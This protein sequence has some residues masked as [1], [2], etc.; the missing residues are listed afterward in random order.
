MTANSAPIAADAK[1]RWRRSTP[2]SIGTGCPPRP[3]TSIEDYVATVA[4]ST[5]LILRADDEVVPS[6]QHFTE[7]LAEHGPDFDAFLF[8]EHYIWNSARLRVAYGTI[9]V[10]PA[11]QQPWHEHMAAAALGVGL[12]EAGEQIDAY[13]QETL[14][15]DY[16]TIM[17]DYHQLAIRRGLDAPQPAPNFLATIVDLAYDG[18]RRRGRGEE[19]LLAPIHRRL[20]IG[21]NPAQHARRVFISDGMAALVAQAAIRPDAIRPASS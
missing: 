19:T 21:E 14:G 3:Y 2:P 4:Q 20:A 9:E 7:Y 12:I 5:Y 17:R 13:V 11:C 1:G 18:L 16:W 8:H 10:R 15:E 6:S